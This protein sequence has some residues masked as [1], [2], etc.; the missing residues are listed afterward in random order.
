MVA[1]LLTAG[2]T[3]G[4]TA[5][6]PPTGATP[7]GE[8]PRTGG[9]SSVITLV[10]GD[11][12]HADAGG[13]VSR[14]RPAE[15]RDHIAMAVR[16]FEGRTY[17]LPADAARLV[18]Q[19][20]LD[21][22]LFDITGLLADGYDDAHRT[23]LPLIVSYTRQ[24]ARAKSAFAAADVSVRRSLPVLSA[25]AVT[26][27][28][29]ASPEVWQALTAPDTRGSSARVAG[30]GIG[31][32]WLDGKR[33]ASLDRSVARIGAPAA[34]RAGY[35]GK[36]VKIAVLDTGVDETHPDLQGTEIAQKDFSGAG[37]TVDHVGHGTHVASIAAGSGAKSGGTYK[38]V[39]PGAKILDGKVLDDSGSGDESGIV[40]GMQWAAD[41]GAKVAN[42]SLGGYDSPEVDPI[43]AAVDRLSAD[44]GILFV[45]AAGNEGPGARTV[46]S[47]GSAASAL[48]VGAVDHADR[49]AAFSSTGPAADGTL[50]P[51]LTAPGVDIVAAKAA[52]GQIGD[53]AAD[54]YVALS[55]TSMATPHVAGAA[56]ILAQEHPDWTGARIKQA[57]TAS[58]APGAGL[59]A[60][61]QGTG[62]VDV[63]RAVTQS[64]V[65]DQTSVSFGVA[66][67]PHADDTPGSRTVTYRNSGDTP[68]TL[69]L[70]VAAT[71]PDGRAAPAG[72]FGLDTARLTVPAG[73]TADAVLTSDTRIA[74]PDGAYSGS[75]VATAT[76]GG[77]R[78]L[79]SFGVLREEESY[80]LTLKFLDAKGRPTAAAAEV[81][82]HTNGV[83]ESPYDEDGDGTVKV[84]VPKGTYLFDVAVDG[85]KTDGAPSLALLVRPQYDVTKNA[86]L[87]FDARRAKPVSITPPGRA[88]ELSAYTNY[89]MMA[90]ADHM[91]G[92]TWFL[93]SFQGVSTAQIGAALPAERFTAQL[94]SLWQQGSTNYHLLYNRAGSVYTGFSRRATTGE[95]ALVNLRIGASAKK[96]TGYV[97]SSWSA[98]GLGIG[99]GTGLFALPT[100]AK[101]YITAPKGFTWD[102]G[103]GQQQSGE[104]DGVRL[105]SDDA[106]NYRAGKTY[107][108]TFNVGVFSPRVG[109]Y[110]GERQD[111]SMIVCVDEFTDGAGH[112]GR[113]A[114]T[115]QRTVITADGR[116]I[117]DKR[118]DL[119]QIVANLPAAAARYVVSTD[120]TRSTA[121]AGVTTRLVASWS[122][123]SE[124]PSAEGADLPLS[125]VRFLPKLDLASTA[126][127]G[128]KFTVPLAIDGPAAGR[129]FKSLSV[130]VSYDG[131]T[132][133]AKAPVTTGKGGKKSLTLSH[134]KKATSVSFRARLT[135]TKG[136]TYDVTVVKAYLLT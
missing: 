68:V 121:L 101:T 29:A 104:E 72:A 86:T 2:L 113:S 18:S 60:Y 15:G 34:W 112:W 102:F 97:S 88:K 23:T 91:F 119:C 39:A 96:R 90:D 57:L 74:G 45:V 32:V 127:A 87:T 43:E 14:V 75:V 84:R 27:P 44:R 100:T 83:W 123:V 20:K 11:R 125:T 120:A 59:S 111:D 58:T 13:R 80:D 31:R 8:A 89:L 109:P 114:V 70:A 78:V 50:K 130:Q 4:V 105:G 115:K 30:A 67:W 25:E 26:V 107:T 42:L 55:G 19:G 33:E 95:L 52:Q 64:V 36:G 128:K 134:P 69:D 21:R 10:T 61:Q 41:Q 54:G 63:A 118:E 131:G 117:L 108:K 66:Q 51:D 6:A 93:N 116:K 98:N 126:A 124:R 65:S 12:V 17:V 135:D 7:A 53:P 56:A 122:F 24:K 76:E 73:G 28:K 40:A 35:D 103:V 1:A 110:S 132:K 85:P 92:S 38:G 37:N 129:G 99:A 5:A 133:W 79:T 48:T 106:K 49:L 94:G 136:Y 71:G 47:P 9:G 22:R 3:T 46:G 77:Q 62:R 16:R 81:V 82:G